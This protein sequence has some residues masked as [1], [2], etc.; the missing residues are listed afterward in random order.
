MLVVFSPCPV[1][2][3]RKSE[4][5]S[6]SM[7]HLWVRGVYFSLKEIKEDPGRRSWEEK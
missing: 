3:Q 1:R 2:A 4:E 7:F 6:K 5:M